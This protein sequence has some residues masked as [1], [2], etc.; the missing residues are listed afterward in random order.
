MR[1]VS[2]IV[3]G[4]VAGLAAKILASSVL[5]VV[6]LVN[7]SGVQAMSLAD[8]VC[9]GALRG[10]GSSRRVWISDGVRKLKS[11]MRMIV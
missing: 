7:G 3:P 4:K 2:T 5:V 6:V 10:V 11:Q 1:Q 8:E 9:V